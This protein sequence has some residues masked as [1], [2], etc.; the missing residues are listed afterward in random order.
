MAELYLGRPIFNGINE[1]D[2]LSKIMSVLG[3]ITSNNWNDGY[4]L[5]NNLGIK[6]NSVTP[7]PL[8]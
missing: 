2:Q 5:A 8:S 3:P 1:Q 7:A 4:H 6:I